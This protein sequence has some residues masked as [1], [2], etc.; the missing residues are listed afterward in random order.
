[1]AREL[2]LAINKTNDPV[3]NLTR[4]LWEAINTEDPDEY[5]LEKIS[6]HGDT[7]ARLH[8]QLGFLGRFELPAELEQALML[9]HGEISFPYPQ[10]LHLASTGNFDVLEH[11]TDSLL[12]STSSIIAVPAALCNLPL[13]WPLVAHEYGHRYLRARVEGNINREALFVQSS[14]EVPE[15]IRAPLQKWKGEILCDHIGRLLFGGAFV[16]PALAYFVNKFAFSLTDYTTSHPAPLVRLTQLLANPSSALEGKVDELCK[17]I[18]RSS[19]QPS[20]KRIVPIA[21]V[22]CKNK[23]ADVETAVITGAVSGEMSESLVKF[24]EYLSDAGLNGRSPRLHLMGSLVD[25]FSKGLPVDLCFSPQ[26]PPGFDPE[27]LSS[28]E[29]ES[30]SK[31]LGQLHC[32]PPTAVELF[33]AAWQ[34]RLD[35]QENFRGNA[36]AFKSRTELKQAIEATLESIFFLGENLRAGIRSL[37]MLRYLEEVLSNDPDRL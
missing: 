13:Y 29:G 30:W 17:D 15:E 23:F 7:T 2:Q 32:D 28:Q 36:G 27:T 37:W 22:T 4:N 19:F 25:A 14:V 11:R 5:L 33:S 34:R 12:G 10:S 24:E 31:L 3:E 1:L 26:L 35:I 21:C 18:E 20:D 16:A 8:R 9:A 6:I